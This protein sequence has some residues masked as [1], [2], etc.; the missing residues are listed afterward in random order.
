MKIKLTSDQLP[1]A[2]IQLNGLEVELTPEQL[3][4]IRGSQD[5]PQIGDKYWRG[6]NVMDDLPYV[7]GHGSTDRFHQS[8]GNLFATK[9][10]AQDHLNW[11]KARARL[12]NKIKLLN[13]GWTPD[14][15]NVKQPKYIFYYNHVSKRISIS[16]QINS[17]I[18]MIPSNLFLKSRELGDQLIKENPDDIK[19]YLGVKE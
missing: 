15:D 17:L 9:Q 6:D 7:F 3:E 13:D 14:W 18:Q 8:T 2:T 4:Q 1:P 12:I 10:E 19:T 16:W 11:L 5:F